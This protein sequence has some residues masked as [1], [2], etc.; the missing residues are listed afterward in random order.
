[1]AKAPD[2]STPAAAPAAPTPPPSTEPPAAPP[3]PKPP[4]VTA[5]ATGFDINLFDAEAAA[6]DLKAREALELVRENLT[7][8]KFYGVPPALAERNYHFVAVGRR[9]VA[10]AEEKAAILRSKG[11]VDAPK[12]VRA[13]GR[14]DDGDQ[15]IILC[16]RPE[17][18]AR[19]HDSKVQRAIDRHERMK[20]RNVAEVEE[21]LRDGLKTGTDLHFSFATGTT[22]DGIRGVDSELRRAV[23]G[24]PR[25]R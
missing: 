17:A 22:S 5:D 25:R 10:R 20:K 7:L 23:S 6:A 18:W 1:M 8:G 16:A 12:S 11:Y 24:L 21:R 19:I 13:I 2:T 3:G 15:L 14:E 9:G 4:P